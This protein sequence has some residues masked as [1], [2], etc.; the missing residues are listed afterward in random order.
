MK[1]LEYTPRCWALDDSNL[2]PLVGGEARIAFAEL[3]LAR[4]EPCE[5]AAGLSRSSNRRSRRSR[6]EE[7]E[8]EQEKEKQE[9]KEEVWLCDAAV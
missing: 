6:R 5:A 3:Q 2:P 9:D 7:Q 4:R 1:T 8:E